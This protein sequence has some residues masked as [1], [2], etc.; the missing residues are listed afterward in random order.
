MGQK[1]VKFL[2]VPERRVFLKVAGHLQL[3]LGKC[4]G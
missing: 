1:P 3:H 2:S 4:F